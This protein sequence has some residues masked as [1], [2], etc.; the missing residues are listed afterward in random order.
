MDPEKNLEVGEQME[1]AGNR[2]KVWTFPGRLQYWLNFAGNNM[3]VKYTFPRVL[4]KKGYCTV[5]WIRK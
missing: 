4:S 3:M 2:Y 1:I 5:S